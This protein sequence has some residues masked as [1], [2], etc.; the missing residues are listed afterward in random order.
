V[1]KW[2]RPYSDVALPLRLDPVEGE[3]VKR[4]RAFR[5]WLAA[6]AEPGGLRALAGE[7]SRDAQTRDER[8]AAA[9]R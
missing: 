7:R 9:R 1:R 2:T 6:G 3:K 4:A 5:L 8:P